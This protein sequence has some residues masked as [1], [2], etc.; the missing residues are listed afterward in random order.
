MIRRLLQRLR[1]RAAFLDRRY[2]HLQNE[3]AIATFTFDDFPRSAYETG[4]KIFEAA[5][6]RA[7]YFTVGSYMGHTIGGVEQFTDGTLRAA[8]AAGHEIGCHTFDHK[9]LGLHNRRF[10]RE[11]CD[12]NLL[13]FRETLHTTETMTSFAYPY[14]DV[15]LPVKDEMALRFPLCRGVHQGMNTGKAD[16]AQLS[17]ISLESLHAERLDLKDLI[18]KA[19]AQKSWLVF[20]CHDISENPSPYGATPTMLESAVNLLTAANIKV[21]TLRDAAAVIHRSTI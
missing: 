16:M 15:S 11:T 13:F 14:G 1:N 3:S 7:T 4:G 12:R 21:L 2:R 19:L 5:G 9:K 6:L 17:V 20:L 18:A 8:H 10:A